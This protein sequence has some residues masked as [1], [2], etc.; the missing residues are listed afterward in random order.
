LVPSSPP[1]TADYQALLL[2]KLKAEYPLTAAE[3]NVLSR[4]RNAST[5]SSSNNRRSNP[6]AYQDSTAFEALLGYLF[7]NND[8]TRLR[9]MLEWLQANV[10]PPPPATTN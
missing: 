2:T 9:S 5:R 6:T 7:I 10:E 8:P 4:G 3:Q 1:T